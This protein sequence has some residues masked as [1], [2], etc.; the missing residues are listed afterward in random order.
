MTIY[1]RRRPNR[2]P[3][4]IVPTDYRRGE[5][6]I[7]IECKSLLIGALK[8]TIIYSFNTLVIFISLVDFFLFCSKRALKFSDL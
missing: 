3:V 8:S 6:D 5:K 2:I 7:P 1:V 4:E